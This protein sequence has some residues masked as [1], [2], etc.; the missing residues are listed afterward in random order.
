MDLLPIDDHLGKKISKLRTYKEI[1][2]QILKQK[3]FAKELKS[4]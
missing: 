1:I 4:L 3:N 2:N